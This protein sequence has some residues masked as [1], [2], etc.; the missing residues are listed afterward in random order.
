MVKRLILATLVACSMVVGAAAQE[1]T[2]IVTKSGDKITGQLVDMGGSGFTVRVSGQERQVPTGDVAAI[3]F[4]GS[5]DVPEADWAR[6]KGG[7]HIIL[8]RNGETIEGR[9]QDISGTRPKR[10]HVQTSSGERE[11]SSTEIGRILMART[12][13]AV[14]TSGPS[15]ASTPGIP[16]GQGI[17]VAGNQQWTP[18]GITV[19][20]GDR[21]T[22][23]ATG[24]VRVSADPS[25]V[26]SANGSKAGRTAPK[27]PVPALPIG[28][29]IGRVGNS[30][31]FPIGE[32]L[33]VTMPANG[34]LFLGIN[35]DHLAD[36]AGG[37]RVQI[38]R[39]SR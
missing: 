12:N 20:Q 28:G 35:D 23:N 33:S 32:Q 22:I 30:A 16:E 26:A 19:R 31:P 38:R 17:A 13:S 24:E 3:D 4:S 25:D 8:L 7:S 14:A 10:I 5:G 39:T 27:A 37:F 18:A 9:L 11:F 6:V 2:T 29:L 36:N 21:L 34:Q 1:N 15:S